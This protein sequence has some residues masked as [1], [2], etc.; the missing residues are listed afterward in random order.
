MRFIY[1]LMTLLLVG[2]VPTRAQVGAVRPPGV[3]AERFARNLRRLVDANGVRSCDL[4]LAG[5]VD[6]NPPLGYYTEIPLSRSFTDGDAKCGIFI[7]HDGT[8]GPSGDLIA[9]YLRL[10][11]SPFEVLVS[12]ETAELPSIRQT[13]PYF[14]SMSR[15]DRIHLTIWIMASIAWD[16]T[17]CGE[18]MKNPG[19]P[20]ATGLFQMERDEK[21]R[22]WR[23]FFCEGPTMEPIPEAADPNGVNVLC[24]MEILRGQYEGLYGKAGLYPDAY[25][26]KLRGQ[27]AGNF[28]KSEILRRIRQHPACDPKRPKPRPIGWSL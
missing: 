25:F 13:C 14:R 12:N 18:R 21:D 27:Y 7:K 19:N 16:E 24:A 15:E 11:P 5:S 4:I 26:E 23:G 1:C 8:L 20:K 22:A 3:E 6:E 17:K 10:E 9:R 2:A 28:S